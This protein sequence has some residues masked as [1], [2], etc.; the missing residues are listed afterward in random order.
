MNKAEYRVM[1]NIQFWNMKRVVGSQHTAWV[2]RVYS[3][4]TYSHYVL[5]H[6]L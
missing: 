3:I 4:V 5:T 6:N 2:F 1:L